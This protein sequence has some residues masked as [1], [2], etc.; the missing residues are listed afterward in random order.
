MDKSAKSAPDRVAELQRA[1]V[2]NKSIGP[3]NTQFRT[4]INELT[5]DEVRVLKSV[6]K[7]VGRH[8]GESPGVCA[9]IL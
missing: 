6:A 2:L 7:K 1:G 5:D 4:A 8:G 9:W 3:L